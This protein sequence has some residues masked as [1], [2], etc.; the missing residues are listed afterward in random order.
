MC[1]Y[2]AARE[3]KDLVDIV[4]CPYNYLIDPRIRASVRQMFNHDTY[5]S[6]L[7]SI[8]FSRNIT[9][10]HF[11][12]FILKFSLDQMKLNLT[13]QIIIIDEA[14]NIEDSCRDSTTCSINKF[15]LETSREELEK[16]SKYLPSPDMRDAADFFCQVVSTE[17]CQ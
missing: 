11:I 7:F 16:C 13:N 8:Q 3:L 14:H 17:L 6:S 1:P 9:R 15:Q 5:T 12:F 4:F 10:H 2:Y